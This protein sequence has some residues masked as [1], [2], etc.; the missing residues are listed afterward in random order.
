MKLL[1]IG[2]FF[3]HFS[4]WYFTP[5]CIRLLPYWP[6]YIEIR[7]LIYESSF[8]FDI[9]VSFLYYSSLKLAFK[10]HVFYFNFLF[11]LQTGLIQ[12]EKS[13]SISVPYLLKQNAHSKWEWITNL[14]T[15]EPYWQGIINDFLSICLFE[16]L[17]Y[18]L[19]WL[20]FYPSHWLIVFYVNVD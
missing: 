3:N 18:I 12:N 16:P 10:Y 15:S 1:T 17:T 9:V 2:M 13:A 4:W 14:S 5:R 19:W 6:F 20:F 11:S 7:I 8:Q